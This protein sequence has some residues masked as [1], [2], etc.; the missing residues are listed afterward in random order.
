MK[1]SWNGQKRIVWITTQKEMFHAYPMAPKGVEFLKSLHRHI[2]KFKV[3]IEVEHNDRDI[4]FILFKRFVNSVIDKMDTD[5][6]I[7]S[8]EMISE[9][10]ELKK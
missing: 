9:Y 3:Y 4:E 7:K 2:F 6:K 10:L 5:L 1:K 8:C